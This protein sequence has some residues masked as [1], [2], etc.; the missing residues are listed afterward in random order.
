M[1]LP[2]RQMYPAHTHFFPDRPT[3][4][5]QSLIRRMRICRVFTFA[6]V[7]FL[8]GLVHNSA[9][10]DSY[11]VV[12]ATNG[13][14][15]FSYALINNDGVV[16]FSALRHDSSGTRFLGVYKSR[17]DAIRTVSEYPADEPTSVP[18]RIT[19]IADAN[20][21]ISI[22]N[23][24]L[25]ALYAHTFNAFQ[26]QQILGI[27]V[28]NGTMTSDQLVANPFT[29]LG[30][31]PTITDNGYLSFG[32]NVLPYPYDPPASGFG[33]STCFG[34][35][36][37]NNR[38]Q[39][40]LVVNA[41]IYIVSIRKRLA[42]NGQT[43]LEPFETNR[44]AGISEQA[45]SAGKR[46]MMNDNGTVAFHD[47]PSAGVAGI[48]KNPATP[49]VESRSGSEFSFNGSFSPFAINN[50]EQVAFAA[51]SRTL[52]K[53]GIFRGPNPLTDK[54]VV[55]GDIVA[56]SRL[57]HLSPPGS[58]DRWFND[59]GQIV[60]LASDNNALSFGLWVTDNGIT[61]SPPSVSTLI[62]WNPP[63]SVPN[64]SF[65]VAANWEPIAGDTPRVPLK[66]TTR[67]DSAVFDLP[68]AYTV[69][70]GTQ[71]V[72][73]AIVKDGNVIFQ[74]GSLIADELS[75]NGPS[76][77][78]NNARLALLTAMTLTANHTLIGESAGS[79]MDV[80]FGGDWINNGSLRVGG[81]GE[82]ILNVNAGGTVKSGEARIGTGV[83]GGRATVTATGKWTT[84][85][86]A[87]G[88][89]GA[90]ALNIENGGFVDSYVAVIGSEAGSGNKATVRGF[91]GSRRSI[92]DSLH[93]IVGARGTGRLEVRDGG[94]VGAGQIKVA[95]ETAASGDIIVSG[96]SSTGLRTWIETGALFV[97]QR[98]AGTLTIEDGGLVEVAA[99]DLFSGELNG[100]GD[101]TVRG[102]H[103]TTS[104]ASSLVVTNNPEGSWYMGPGSA[105]VEAGGRIEVADVLAMGSGLLSAGANMTIVGASARV[106]A[107]TLLVGNTGNPG[108]ATV[109]LIGGTMDAD[110]LWVNQNG[111]IQ[112]F[113]SLT[114][115]ETN[116]VHNGGII[117][118]G[119]SPG[120][121]TVQGNY[122]QLPEG[123]LVI[124]LGGT[125]AVDH[126][127]FIV[128][129]NATLD[130]NVTLRFVDGFAPRAG[131]S[132]PFLNVSGAVSGEFTSVGL[133]NLA[134]GFQFQFV[135]NGVQLGITALNAGVFSSA[136]R[137]EVQI[138]ITNVGG[139]T[140]AS[141]TITTSNTCEKVAL[142]GSLSRTNNVFSQ[143]FQGTTFV[144]PD[145][146][147]ETATT[148]GN[149]VLGQLSPGNYS[150]RM[151]S[152]T[153]VV[154]S[155]SF[156]I[157]AETV[158]TLSR[159]TLLADGSL[160]FEIA[161]LSPI[162]YTIEASGDLENWIPLAQGTLPFTYVDP[163]A[164]IYPRRFYR[165]IIGE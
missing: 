152:N 78:I 110:E 67:N 21:F 133:E 69:D 120:V 147:A 2:S 117:S 124:E 44:V 95:T 92:W 149:I 89:G 98:G 111:M 29:G 20:G 73:R 148:S 47:I 157:G 99:G 65:A 141:Y 112:G 88:A 123:S 83:G 68:I 139:I 144:R 59:V 130:G 55:E 158:Q 54:I 113:G 118:P 85:P 125:N 74:N 46:P 100:I 129:S 82:G 134:P 31:L 50:R 155:V 14:S 18:E 45:R 64:G 61:P 60:F 26:N 91:D 105:I 96:V 41:N 11:R 43:F 32:V 121:L 122:E 75:T 23:R 138:V 17:G 116:R 102:V 77:V 33:C 135:T 13:F 5:K 119:L 164:V 93:L 28:G 145:C 106:R 80:G 7:I 127:Q 3:S 52:G 25:T 36:R 48:Y 115:A 108:G 12:H 22:N 126:D 107:K 160:Q 86:I 153:Q 151:I 87:I 56:G 132:F 137:G 84:G 146:V 94:F 62:R 4:E 39:Y 140:Y 70:I 38:L 103:A 109:T 161:G 9:H 15:N 131:D 143:G 150:L 49:V 16:I 163:D 66:N 142:R 72:A 159:P 71:H 90:G 53:A 128:T 101:I 136:L 6:F 35:G 97:G 162:Q 81:S 76:V 40:L 63:V 8:P 34:S 42:D 114:V 165:A 79:R 37:L 156:T 1:G 19:V 154:E 57:T 58:A 27:Y 104:L 10:G 30:L 24:G 51:V